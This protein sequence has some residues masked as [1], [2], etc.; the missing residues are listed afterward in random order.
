MSTRK[1]RVITQRNIEEAMALNALRNG[2]MSLSARKRGAKFD[3]GLFHNWINRGRPTRTR[4]IRNFGVGSEKNRLAWPS[5]EPRILPVELL[6][7]DPRHG[8]GVIPYPRRITSSAQD[9]ANNAAGLMRLRSKAFK[10]AFEGQ[11]LNSNP[12]YY[13]T[14][15]FSPTTRSIPRMK[16]RR[17]TPK[18]PSKK[19]GKN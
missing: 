14:V 5:H 7:K 8:F 3:E 10:N 4:Q 12:S 1:Q 2:S 15:G 11:M 9:I 17:H 16:P 13:Y 18:S 6:A 19:R